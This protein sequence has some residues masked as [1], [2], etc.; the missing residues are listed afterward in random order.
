MKGWHLPALNKARGSHLPLKRARNQR[1]M[2]PNV[3]VQSLWREMGQIT[4]N[5]STSH[6]W[7]G[8]FTDSS[9]RQ[10]WAQWKDTV[11]TATACC[12]WVLTCGNRASLP[13][14]YS[15][16]CCSL[17]WLTQPWWTFYC[18]LNNFCISLNGEGKLHWTSVLAHLILNGLSG[19][20]L[21]KRLWIWRVL[22]ILRWW[23]YHHTVY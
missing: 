19:Q 20:G 2:K 5:L 10:L 17:S 14:S 11:H 9:W 16:S 23:P 21:K 8:V 3:G 4:G 6:A 7:K 15:R 1:W 13:G 22:M 12:G 18:E